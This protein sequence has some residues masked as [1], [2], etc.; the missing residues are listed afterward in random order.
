MQAVGVRIAAWTCAQRGGQP[1][2]S[3]GAVESM[4][5][6]PCHAPTLH[7][8][9]QKIT[10]HD[11][12]AL[13]CRSDVGD[14]ST[15]DRLRLGQRRHRRPAGS[16]ASSPDRWGVD[17]SSTT[18]TPASTR[19]S[20]CTDAT[21]PSDNPAAVARA[22]DD[23]RSLASPSARAG[24]ATSGST[25]GATSASAAHALASTIAPARTDRHPH[26]CRPRSDAA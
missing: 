10:A 18:D 5:V 19:P 4:R 11:P 20:T 9:S 8:G 14:M 7:I 2:G 15:L 16:H 13:V 26:L 1:P 22:S 17:R 21:G 12:K 6:P 25:T 3:P 24:G 23:A